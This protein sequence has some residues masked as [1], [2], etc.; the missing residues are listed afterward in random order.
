MTLSAAWAF[1]HMS[2]GLMVSAVKTTA[3]ESYF[4]GKRAKK[5][6]Q[7]WFSV[8]R[9]RQLFLLSF[10]LMLVVCSSPCKQQLT[11]KTACSGAFGPHQQSQFVEFWKNLD[12]Q[13]FSSLMI[14]LISM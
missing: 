2:Q 10:V 13:N 1:A 11:L 12:V 5:W 14:R 6:Q 9:N 8:V 3:Q 7:A 4:M